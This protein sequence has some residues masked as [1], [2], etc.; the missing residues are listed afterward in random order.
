MTVALITIQW[1]FPTVQLSITNVSSHFQGILYWDFWIN[2]YLIIL[3]NLCIYSIVPWPVNSSYQQMSSSPT[4][5]TSCCIP[6][7][8]VKGQILDRTWITVLQLMVKLSETCSNSI[9]NYRTAIRPLPTPN[10]NSWNGSHYLHIW[11][12]IW[13]P[14]MITFH[15]NIR[16][17]AQKQHMQCMFPN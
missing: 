5:T 2:M 17:I 14:W 6:Y 16:S 11:K 4:Q 9:P 12:L 1:S 13:H 15:T 8:K 10:K 3:T 7:S